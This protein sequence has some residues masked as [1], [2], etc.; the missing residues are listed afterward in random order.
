MFLFLEN[1]LFW[2]REEAEAGSG[3]AERDGAEGQ[4]GG[5]RALG[6]TSP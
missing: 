2:D 5:Q 4:H 3:E 6:E 1:F